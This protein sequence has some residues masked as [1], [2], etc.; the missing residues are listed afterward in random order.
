MFTALFILFSPSPSGPI[1]GTFEARIFVCPISIFLS[2]HWLWDALPGIYKWRMQVR[3]CCRAASLRPHLFLISNCKHFLLWPPGGRGHLIY[4]TDCANQPICVQ[5]HHFV[6]WEV[7]LDKA[8]WRVGRSCSVV[9]PPPS[10]TNTW[11]T[12]HSPNI[13]EIKIYCF[14]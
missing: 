6:L 3:A 2:I 9:H 5:H 7:T 13:I 1:V 12:F 10:L 4:N 14:L 8:E 11:F